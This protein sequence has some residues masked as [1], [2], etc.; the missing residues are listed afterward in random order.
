LAILLLRE[1]RGRVRGEGRDEEEKGGK[2]REDATH[3]YGTFLAM[4]LD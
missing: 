3:H 2:G 4:P 1:R